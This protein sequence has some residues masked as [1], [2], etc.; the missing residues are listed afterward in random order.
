MLDTFIE[1]GQRLVVMM[2]TSKRGRVLRYIPTFMLG[3]PV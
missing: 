2:G 3:I 1:Q